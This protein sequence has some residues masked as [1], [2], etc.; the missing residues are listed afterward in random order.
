MVIPSIPR[1]KFIKLMSFDRIQKIVVCA[2]AAVS[3]SLVGN[4]V[5]VSALNDSVT[6]CVSDKDSSI[7]YSRDKTCKTGAETLLTLNETGPAGVTGS[8]GATG[9]T[10]IAGSKGATGATGATGA[11]G[12][13]GGFATTYS[14]KEISISHTLILT[15]AGK[16]LISRDGATISLPTNDSVSFPI[17]TRIEIANRKSFL[18]VS[19]ASG[20]RLNFLSA[21]ISFDSGDY[22][23]GTLIKVDTND[24]VLMSSPNE[25]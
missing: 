21:A 13:A 17:G 18:T 8:K 9:A 23:M 24:W 5:V 3:A 2:L 25:F 10:G 7:R 11:A 16:I 6:I 22:Q 4:F 19:P 12:T 15:D 20:V 14:L 1:R